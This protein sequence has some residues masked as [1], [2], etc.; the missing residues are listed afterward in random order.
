MKKR[1]EKIQHE[2][3]RAALHGV[4]VDPYLLEDQQSIF[5]KMKAKRESQKQQQQQERF[6]L[7][8]QPE[9]L[10]GI[11]ETWMLEYILVQP[12]SRRRIISELKSII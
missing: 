2:M 10:R 9:S 11:N 4:D 3:N 12:R 7:R 8:R 6:L 1:L 5:S